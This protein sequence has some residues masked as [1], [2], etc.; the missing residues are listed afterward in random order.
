MYGSALTKE[1]NRNLMLAVISARRDAPKTIELCGIGSAITVACCEEIG[2]PHVK[3]LG[4]KCAD[5][6]HVGQPQIGISQSIRLS[7]LTWDF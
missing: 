5:P 3:Q 4:V 7:E 6:L 1:D 2:L